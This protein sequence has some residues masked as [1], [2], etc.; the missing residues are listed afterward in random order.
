MSVSGVEG[1]QDS[2]GRDRMTE[3][4]SN[5]SAGGTTPQR[6]RP[7]R[8]IPRIHPGG[9]GMRSTAGQLVA[10]AERPIGS[11]P[12]PVLRGGYSGL[13]VRS[14]PTIAVLAAWAAEVEPCC[15]PRESRK[16]PR[17]YRCQ[18]RLAGAAWPVPDDQATANGTSA[19]AIPRRSQQP[20][21]P[22]S[23]AASG[24]QAPQEQPQPVSAPSCSIV[25][26]PR[27]LAS[28]IARSVTP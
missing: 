15:C 11:G 10:D 24:R 9:T 27:A 7:S 25:A 16:S 18:R 8:S 20:S 23:S 3:C 6:E 26:I 1:L 4:E 12:P 28:R 5:A 21:Q 22:S 17:G 19:R 13:G 14:L 2:R